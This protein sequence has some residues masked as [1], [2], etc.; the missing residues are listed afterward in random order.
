MGTT[1]RQKTA[2]IKKVAHAGAAAAS[3]AGEDV[4]GVPAQPPV[5]IDERQQRQA[6]ER[7]IQLFQSRQ[8]G[9]AFRLFEMAAAGPTREMAHTAKLRAQMC[10]RRIAASEPSFRT[11]DELYDYAVALINARRLEEAERRLREAVLKAPAGDHIYYALALCR[12]LA[13]DL[14]GAYSNLKHAIEL[15]PR[16]RQ[17]ARNDP[18]FAEIATL[19]PLVQ[20][21]YPERAA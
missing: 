17:Q 19:P 20:L 21:L 15:Q 18:D 7:A 6:F 13:G 16:N 9:A 5:D 8:Y 2:P 1:S 12:G 3:P 14:R 4:S 11:A 10:R